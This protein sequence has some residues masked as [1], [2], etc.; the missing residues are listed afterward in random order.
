MSFNYKCYDLA[1]HRQG[2]IIVLL[3]ITN[4]YTHKHIYTEVYYNALEGRS[5]SSKISVSII[6][7]YACGKLYPQT[8]C[9]LT[10]LCT[11]WL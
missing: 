6:F 11:Q 7:V 5:R 1:L 4:I 8:C 10:Q 3:Y 2:N 9:V